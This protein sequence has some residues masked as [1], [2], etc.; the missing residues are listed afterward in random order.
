MRGWITLLAA[1]ATFQWGS[2]LSSP[3][4]NP[5]WNDH[6]CKMKMRPEIKWPACSLRA[7][8]ADMW[9][10]KLNPFLGQERSKNVWVPGSANLH[11]M[12]VFL[13]GH[14]FI[15]HRAPHED[16]MQNGMEANV[17]K[18]D[19][20]CI[21]EIEI[22]ELHWL[23]MQD[24]CELAASCFVSSP[25]KEPTLYYGI[26]IEIESH[27]SIINL[28]IMCG[29]NTTQ[30][31]PEMH[32]NVS[33]LI[34]ICDNIWI[35]DHNHHKNASFELISHTKRSQSQYCPTVFWIVS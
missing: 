28:T 34:C 35:V 33:L 15:K 23:R 8:W 18:N 19:A 2:T 4:S 14:I 1:T 16:A 24:S 27:G 13:Y 31:K 29:A 11:C 5:R 25:H 7:A 3:L 9:S 21:I 10:G 26:A 20:K 30:S 22:N 6:L 17:R 12:P 32:Q